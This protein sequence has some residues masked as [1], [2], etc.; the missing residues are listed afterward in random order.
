MRNSVNL[1]QIEA[2]YSVMRTGTVV[3]AA[4]MM[5]VTQP[6]VSRA[7]AHLEIR[8]GYDL[9]E[10]RGRKLVATPEAQALYAELEPIY[11]N[12]DRI[13]QVAH[14]IGHQRAGALR[15][16]TL[17]ALSQSLVPRTVARFAAARP[18]VSVFVQTLPSRQIAEMVATKQFDIGIV[19]LPLSQPSISIE[20]LE[21]LERALVLPVGHR[22]ARRKRISLKELD[23]ERMILLSQHS[24]M[25]YQIDDALSKLRVSVQVAME[26]PNSLV[27]CALVAE[28]AG[29][30]L[31]SRITAEPFVSAGV[32][33]RPV[34]EELDTR[35]AIIFPYPGKR[36]ALAETFAADLRDELRRRQS[37]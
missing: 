23:G 13:A 25:R 27:A 11:G 33:I 18:Q 21:P 14:D 24:Y 22:L 35:C 1:R 29:I 9:F 10:R 7:I 28:G 16:A 20:P 6:A 34:V 15:I 37:A 36:L 31:V 30:T 3:G 8:I 17:P 12:L 19:E 2:F 4:Q 32:V 5:S 26:T